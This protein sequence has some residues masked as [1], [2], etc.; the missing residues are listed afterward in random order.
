MHHFVA[1]VSFFG[2][3]HVGSRWISYVKMCVLDIK[4]YI[5]RKVK[6]TSLIRDQI[7]TKLLYH[8]S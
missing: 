8:D 7:L 5:S 1:F 3:H 2:H 4:C 6:M